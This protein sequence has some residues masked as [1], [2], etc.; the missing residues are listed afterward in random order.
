[1]K[2]PVFVLAP[3]SFKGSMTARQVCDAMERGIK[4]VYPD[5]E[6]IK[7]P[8]ADGGE[9]TVQ[10]LV[11]ATGGKLYE[12]WV[13]NPMGKPVLAQYGILGDG[14]TA[15]IEMAAASGLNLIE[16]KDRNPLVT[17]TYGVGELMLAALEKKVKRIILGIGGSATNDGGAGFA[18]ALGVHLYDEKG[19]EVAQGGAALKN[20]CRIDIS[21]I[22]KR[23]N[24]VTI[25][26]ASDVT[27]P[28]C[29]V[30][31]ASYVYG[32]QKGATREMVAQLD[33]ALS[34]YADVIKSGLGKDVKDIPGA[35]A[36]GGLGAGLLAFTNTR[37]RSGI[38]IVIE[39]T[40]LRDAVRKAD[41]VFT[42]EGKIDS[43]TK[44]GKTPYG[45]AMLA[46]AERKKVV[47][48]AGKIEKGVDDLYSQVFDSILSISAENVPVSVSM[49]R[50]EVYVENT[51]ARYLADNQI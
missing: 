9:G 29:G 32:P 16:E 49:E 25:E 37:L 31:G 45:V 17:T 6:C 28:L 30:N 12:A 19:K 23:L 4:K 3:D 22:D 1:M 34:H 15:V 5:S 40:G 41:I 21:S 8:M 39:Y 27:N 47:A 44:N 14:D 50:G 13:S 35:G 33:E 36:A 48:I 42:G 18:Q 20:L 10:S 43:Q 38:D 24:N 46:K 51:I 2:Q 7:V 11:D 26:A